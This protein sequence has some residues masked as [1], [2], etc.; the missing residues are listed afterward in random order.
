MPK[1]NF[2]AISKRNR[3]LRQYEFQ[4]VGALRMRDSLQKCPLAS[5]Y[6]NRTLR[7]NEFSDGRMSVQVLGMWGK[8]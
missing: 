2:F 6:R 3:E 4:T 1:C 7:Q 8:S 5:R